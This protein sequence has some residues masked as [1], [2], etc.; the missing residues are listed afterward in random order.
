MGGV[1]IKILD[2]AKSRFKQIKLYFT[3]ELDL[4]ELR[5]WLADNGFRSSEQII[6]G[7]INS[8]VN[9]V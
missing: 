4:Y 3:T 5:K 7:K 6:N 1:L 2:E 9:Y 8:T